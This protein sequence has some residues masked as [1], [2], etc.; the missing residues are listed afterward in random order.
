[1][2]VTI[3]GFGARVKEARHSRGLSQKD[4]IEEIEKAFPKRPIC[5]RT[6]KR[7]EK[8]DYFRYLPRARVQICKIMPELYAAR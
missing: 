6:L 5:L 4:L 7:I 2:T 8:G 1:M 3:H